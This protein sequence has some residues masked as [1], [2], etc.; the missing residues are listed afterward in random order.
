M[1]ATTAPKLA[2]SLYTRSHQLHWW[3]TGNSLIQLVITAIF[4]VAGITVFTIIILVLFLGSSNNSPNISS[5]RRQML[6]VVG[7]KMPLSLQMVL[8]PLLQH[9]IPIIHWIIVILPFLK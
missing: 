5:P 1:V 9:I 2:I 7:E 3:L 6:E 4:A 8:P